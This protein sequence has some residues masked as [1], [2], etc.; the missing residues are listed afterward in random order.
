MK[1]WRTR[2]VSVAMSMLTL[3]GVVTLG[4]GLAASS[5]AFAD[6]ETIGNTWSAGWTGWIPTAWCQYS[7]ATGEGCIYYYSYVDASGGLEWQQWRDNSGNYYIKMV[8]DEW[9]GYIGFQF[10]Y[11]D[12]A[13]VY[14]S[15]EVSTHSEGSTQISTAYS[16][17]SLG[18]P[19]PPS[20]PVYEPCTE[21]N[22]NQNGYHFYAPW[23][24]QPSLF[25]T[26]ADGYLAVTPDGSLYQDEVLTPSF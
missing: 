6:A 10:G 9:A 22:Y 19:L 1:L 3:T 25:Y 20:D 24:D 18:C 5:P 13:S 8:Q 16:N 15:G 14:S 21:S 2:Q 12:Q 7:D 11:E 4:L 26:S 23:T 17:P